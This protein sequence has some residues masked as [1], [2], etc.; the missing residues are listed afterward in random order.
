MAGNFGT[1][2]LLGEMDPGNVYPVA[3]RLR[4]VCEALAEYSPGPGWEAATDVERK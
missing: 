1:L 2:G 3:A 4:R